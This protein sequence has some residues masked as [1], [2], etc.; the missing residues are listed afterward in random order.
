M[1]SD[2]VPARDWSLTPSSPHP[3]TAARG[4]LTRKGR[5]HAACGARDRLTGRKGV[6]M[7]IG[8]FSATIAAAALALACAATAT[9][10]Q[11]P[12]RPVRLVVPYPAGGPTDFTGRI[13]GQKLGA[14]VGQQIV[15]DNRPGAGTVI[16]SELVARSAPDGYTL[17]FG[18][19]GGTF[20]APIILPK[21][22]YD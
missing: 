9:A 2:S 11:Y 7:S 21:V 15:V 10:Q 18:T 1:G 20:L 19:G 12:L 6:A 14:L 5:V 13:V 3:Q 16:G 4:S 22:P 8:P 17:L